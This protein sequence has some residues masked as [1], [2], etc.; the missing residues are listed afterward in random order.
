MDIV[1]I[2]LDNIGVEAAER[3]GRIESAIRSRSVRAP[4]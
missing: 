1:T 3:I 2:R 4:Q